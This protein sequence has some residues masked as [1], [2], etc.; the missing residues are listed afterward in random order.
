MLKLPDSV[1]RELAATGLPC[2]VEMG[3]KMTK[4][5]IENTYVGSLR[6]GRSEAS[7]RASRNFIASVRRYLRARETHHA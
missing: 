4:V 1:T 5:Y 7:Q 2:R 6:P 3:G